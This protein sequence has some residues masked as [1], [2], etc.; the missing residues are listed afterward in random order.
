[1]I[2]L[3]KVRTSDLKGINYAP[4][5]G[6]EIRKRFYNEVVPEKDKAHVRKEKEKH[7]LSAAPEW[8]VT[9][10]E[11][12]YIREEGTIEISYKWKLV[13]DLHKIIDKTYTARYELN[14]ER[15]VAST[16]VSNERTKKIAA[17]IAPA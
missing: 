16:Q 3:F 15:F 13:S 4:L 12:R 10:F 6:N 8:F 14:T 17:C 1:M 11:Y 7:H 2:T 9:D 5:D